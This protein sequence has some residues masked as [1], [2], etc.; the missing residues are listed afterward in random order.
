M[1]ECDTCPRY[2]KSL[3]ACRRHMDDN[4]HWAVFECET[5]DEEFNCEEEADLHMSRYK[6]YAPKIP[7]DTCD[8]KFHTQ[9][10]ADQHMDALGHWV[11]PWPCETCNLMFFSEST[12]EKHMREK[13]HYRY[14]CRPCDRR[15]QNENNLKMHLNSKIHRGQDIVCP[16]C[17]TG[18]ATATG[19]THHL[20]RG[21]CPHAP[22]LNREA[23]YKFIRSRDTQGILTKKMLEWHEDDNGK[24]T[25]TS[26]AFNGKSWECYICHRKFNTS[27]A[28]SQH[29]NSTVHKQ[30]LYHCPNMTGRCGKEFVTLAALFNH[31][32]SESCGFT[33]FEKVQLQAQNLFDRNKMIAF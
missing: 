25:A 20:E 15:F 33:R 18:F 1:Y 28:L 4:D 13:N 7:C 21:S 27:A 22:S 11:P 23:I 2:F 24:Y 14:Y 29:L 12:A 10:S 8:R 9:R 32:E 6:H 3:F 17:K 16:F 31:L 5:C 30:K 19:V 26:R